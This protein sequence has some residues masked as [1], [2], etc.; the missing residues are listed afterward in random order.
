MREGPVFTK[1][2]E[3]RSTRWNRTDG[4]SGIDAFDRDGNGS[5]ASTGNTEPGREFLVKTDPDYFENAASRSLVIPAILSRR[6]SPFAH[7]P[8]LLRRGIRSNNTAI[9]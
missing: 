8:S 9:N 7:S 3:C 1:I 4:T 2:R 5:S 6:L